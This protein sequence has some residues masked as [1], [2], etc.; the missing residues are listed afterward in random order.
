MDGRRFA[1]SVVSNYNPRKG[2]RRTTYPLSASCARRGCSTVRRSCR[3]RTM[4]RRSRTWRSRTRRRSAPSSASCRRSCP[5]PSPPSRRLRRRS[6]AFVHLQK[7]KE[8]FQCVKYL[9]LPLNTEVTF[10]FIFRRGKRAERG[11]AEKDV[12]IPSFSA[13]LSNTRLTKGVRAEQHAG[14]VI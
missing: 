10:A 11:E 14:H 12:S 6:R 4:A 13:K 2:S 5:R 8:E 3:S 9:R 7:K 1:I